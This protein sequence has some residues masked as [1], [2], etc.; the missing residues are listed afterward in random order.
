MVLTRSASAVL[1]GRVPLSLVMDTQPATRA[2]LCD[3]PRQAQRRPFIEA[4]RRRLG[5][6]VSEP[7]AR[8]RPAVRDMLV[9]IGPDGAVE[10]VPIRW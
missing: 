8:P 4:A 1:G 6:P 5:L 2:A 10:F 7:P 3:C 9:P